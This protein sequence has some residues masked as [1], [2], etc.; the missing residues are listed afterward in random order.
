MKNKAVFLDR[1]KTL[2]IPNNNNFIYRVGDFHIPPEFIESLSLVSRKGYLLFLVTNQ[3]RVAKGYLSED[4]VRSV[5]EH[6]DKVFHGHGVK[7]SEYAYCPHNPVGNIEPYNVVCGCRKPKSG[8]FKKIIDKYN[9]DV[10]VSWMIGDTERD[11]KA[12]RSCGLKT[13][14][15][16]TGDFHFSESADYVENDLSSAVTRIIKG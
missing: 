10:R 9:V 8:L 16:R 13:V 12:G 2:L 14:L 11:M 15:V 7:F 1:D 5:H 4:D 6:I 3:G